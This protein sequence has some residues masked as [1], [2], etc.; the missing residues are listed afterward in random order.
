VALTSYL[1][2][3]SVAFAVVLV[4]GADFAITMRN[5]LVGGRAQGFATA[6]GI[7]AACAVQGAAAVL[8][9]SALIVASQPLFQAISWAGMLYLAFL[10]AQAAVAAWRGAYPPLTG[11]AARPHV[12]FRQGF[13]SNITNPKVLV[14]YLAVLPHFLGD[15]LGW[16][17]I[18]VALT[19]AVLALVWLVGLALVVAWA[20]PV[21]QRRSVRR[22]L[23][24]VTA[25][26]LG[27][28]SLSLARA[29]V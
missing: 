2:F 13:L 10:A 7:A 5:T 19:H 14:F 23:D 17:A 11:L 6:A 15:G 27:A 24:A 26:V 16:T 21:L 29:Q 9:L 25:T 22:A 18:A 20:A 8:G 1:T 12:G 28:F 4:P 3:V